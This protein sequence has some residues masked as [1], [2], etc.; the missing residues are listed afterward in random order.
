MKVRASHEKEPA[1]RHLAIIMDGN[2]RWA[3]K[4]GLPRFMGHEQGAKTTED[5][6]RYASELGIKYIT[7]YAFSS[8]NWQ[9]PQDEIDAVMKILEHYLSNDPNELI[10]ND[11]KMAAIGDVDRLPSYLRKSLEDVQEK[12]KHCKKLVITLALSYGAWDEITRACKNIAAAVQKDK[13]NLEKIDHQTIKDHLFTRD[14]PDPD[15]FIRTGGEIRLSNFLLLQISYS[16]LYFSP[17]L[18]PDFSRA[19]LDRAIHSF[20]AR[21]RRFGAV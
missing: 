3:L 1:L 14:L 19:D 13:I 20:L 17:V 6:V 15:L 4:R 21:D 16:E 2:G 7:L 11:I 18:W 9:R 8:E 12:T 5:I 10:K